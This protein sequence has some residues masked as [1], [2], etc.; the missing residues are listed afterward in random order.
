MG[1]QA[2][3]L[4]FGGTMKPFHYVGEKYGVQRPLTFYA[5]DRTTADGYARQ[6]GKKHRIKIYRRV[7]RA[8][9]N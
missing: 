6:W 5:P 9:R 1:I 7:R 3:A 2:G 4:F 8:K